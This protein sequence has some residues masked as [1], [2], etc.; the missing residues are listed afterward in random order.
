MTT[1]MDRTRTHENPGSC[2]K[3]G[4]PS[5]GLRWDPKTVGRVNSPGHLIS[6]CDVCGYEWRV[7]AKDEIG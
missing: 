6:F 3:C 7:L 2:V 4:G 1:T 5:G